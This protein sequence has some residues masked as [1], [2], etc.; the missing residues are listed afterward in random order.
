VEEN[1]LHRQTIVNPGLTII[2]M[3][4]DL[5]K[6]K[7]NTVGT[8]ENMIN[9][10]AVGGIK[11]RLNSGNHLIREDGLSILMQ[12]KVIICN[13]RVYVPSYPVVTVYKINVS[14]TNG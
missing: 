12:E 2:C 4:A 6:Q 8:W 1:K 13:T 5:F 3:F 14:S 11:W 10:L 9:F 7:F